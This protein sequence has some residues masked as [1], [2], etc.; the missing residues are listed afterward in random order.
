MRNR[1]DA[2]GVPGANEGRF[3]YTGQAWIGELGLYHYKARFYSPFLGRFMQTDPIGY[4]GG[5]NI[6][7]YVGNDP[8]NFSDPSGLA[9]VCVNTTET[10]TKISQTRCVDVDGDRDGNSKED[11]IGPKEANRIR[12][13]FGSYIGR[14][15]TRPGTKTPDLARY[16]KPISGDAN[17]AAKNKISIISQFYGYIAAQVPGS[18][19]NSWNGMQRIVVN[20][21][22]HGPAPAIWGKGG[23]EMIFT[24]KSLGAHPLTPLYWES[25]S[26]LGR[27][28]IHEHGHGWA[29]DIHHLSVDRHARGLL[30][31]FGMDG[32]GCAATNGFPGC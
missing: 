23:T 7:A 25:Y 10:G 24:G 20:R 4:G 31:S 3:Q 1:Y 30:H 19:G 17:D 16:Q 13:S 14:F 2:W 32:E 21:G 8:V 18:L 29:P 15:G 5:T 6:Y 22:P 12:R 28:M 27:I 11:D 26:E 9:R